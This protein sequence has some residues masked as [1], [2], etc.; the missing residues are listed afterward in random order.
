[1]LSFY[2]ISIVY[3]KVTDYFTFIKENP[4]WGATFLLRLEN[5][6]F[7]GKNSTFEQ[8]HLENEKETTSL[9]FRDKPAQQ[10]LELE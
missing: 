5:L 6:F 9:H 3:N 7:S 10:E 8:S 1:M 4:K 2:A